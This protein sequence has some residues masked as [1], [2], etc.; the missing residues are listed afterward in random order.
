M[1]EQTER[2]I[3][4]FSINRQTILRQN[5]IMSRLLEAENASREKDFD[6]KEK[7]NRGKVIN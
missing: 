5:N 2:E 1:M 6:K 4:N 7:V 3:S